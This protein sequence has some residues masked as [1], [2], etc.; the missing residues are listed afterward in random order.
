LSD[1]TLAAMIANY[2]PVYL[3]NLAFA[4]CICTCS[5]GPLFVFDTLVQEQAPSSVEKSV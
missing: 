1:V 4:L 3:E 2:H 5:C